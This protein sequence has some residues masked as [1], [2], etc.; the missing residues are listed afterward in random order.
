LGYLPSADKT[1]ITKPHTT[2][3]AIKNVLDIL[4]VGGR[5]SLMVYY[6]H[7]GGKSERDAVIAF[8]EQLPQNNFATMLYQ[9]LNQVNTPPFLIMVE[10]LQS[11]ENEV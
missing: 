5:L 7:D 6:G 1:V 9:P 10:K 8:V 11:Y 3:K 4:E 2:I